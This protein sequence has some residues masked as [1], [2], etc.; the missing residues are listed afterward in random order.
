L[1]SLKEREIL[2][3]EKSLFAPGEHGTDNGQKKPLLHF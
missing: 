3:F 2:L 1:K